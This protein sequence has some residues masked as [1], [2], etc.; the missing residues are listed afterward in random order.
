MSDL[1][2][3]SELGGKIREISNLVFYDLNK[4]DEALTLPSDI[5]NMVLS[6][7]PQND[8]VSSLMVSTS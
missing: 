8:V 3:D 6:H 5:K 7:L 4:P 2:V 1:P